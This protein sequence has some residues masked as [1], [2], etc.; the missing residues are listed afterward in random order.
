MG[1]PQIAQ[2]RKEADIA[3]ALAQRDTQMQQANGSREADIGKSAADQERVK[4]ESVSLALQAESQRNLSLKKAEFDAEVKKQQASADKAY[5]IQA[6]MM[7]QQVV[8]EAVR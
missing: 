5:D 8:T 2:I 4:A 1:R 7:Q 6:N 3:A